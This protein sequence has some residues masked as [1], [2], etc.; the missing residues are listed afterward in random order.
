MMKT[1]TKLAGL[2]L[3]VLISGSAF[4]QNLTAIPAAPGTVYGAP[5]DG[6]VVHDGFIHDSY[7]GPIHLDAAPEPLFTRV[8]YKDKKKAHPCA[9]TKIIRVNDPCACDD[10]C[11][12]P[13]CVFIEICV[14]PCGCE[15]VK[16]R[17]DGDRLR[18]DY[19]KYAV[20]IRVKKGY[21]VVDYKR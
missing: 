6:H 15:N 4:A 7:P 18:Y 3:A 17:R 11:C 20:D 5:I 8:K 9:V 13:K 2:S 12:G 14:P 16:C 19:G 21:I 10:G 1:F